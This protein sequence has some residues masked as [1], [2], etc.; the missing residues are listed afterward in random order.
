MST[1]VV[2]GSAILKRFAPGDLSVEELTALQ[3]AGM[4]L[5]LGVGIFSLLALIPVMWVWIA[6]VP[7]MPALGSIVVGDS[8]RVFDNFKSAT[9]VAAEQPLKWFDSIF[10]K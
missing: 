5:V 10:T 2:S 3:R 1:H 8:A 9:A 4:Q 7:T 6:H